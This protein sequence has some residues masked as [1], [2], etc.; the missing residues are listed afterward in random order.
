V[1]RETSTSLRLGAV[2][3]VLASLVFLGFL[4][5]VGGLLVGGVAADILLDRRSDAD[6]G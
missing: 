2:G 4:A 3:C 6:A 1:R 5:A